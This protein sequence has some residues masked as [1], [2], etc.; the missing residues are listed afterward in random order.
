[1]KTLPIKIVY[2]HYWMRRRQAN[3]PLRTP[4]SNKRINEKSSR[5]R[6]Y[7]GARLMISELCDIWHENVVRFAP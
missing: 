6:I 5:G 3:L 1:M 7:F 2:A 4:P